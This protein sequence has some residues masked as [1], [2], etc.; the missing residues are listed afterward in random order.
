MRP[1]AQLQ[2]SHGC[3]DINHSVHVALSWR[4][5]LRDHTNET[6]T[7]LRSASSTPETSYQNSSMLQN[8]HSAMRMCRSVLLETGTPMQVSAAV[9]AG[10]PPA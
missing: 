2:R 8:A 10:V 6:P 7:L 1:C 9:S 4:R 5:S 3:K